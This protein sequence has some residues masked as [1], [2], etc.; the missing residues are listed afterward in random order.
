MKSVDDASSDG[1]QLPRLLKPAS[2]A[3]RLGVSRTWLYDAAKAG[4]VPSVRLG[5]PDG[6]LRFVE[7]DLVAWLR[8]A[9]AAWRPGDTFRDTAGR[10]RRAV[11][12]A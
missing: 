8:E 1:T 12:A 6:P 4:L 9:R 3:E 7:D 11:R 2:V 10:A 5:R